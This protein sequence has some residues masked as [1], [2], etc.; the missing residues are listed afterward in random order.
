MSEMMRLEYI[1]RIKTIQKMRL[2]LPDQTNHLTMDESF[3]NQ[4]AFFYSSSFENLFLQLLEKQN[5]KNT[6]R[7]CSKEIPNDGN[8]CDQ[9]CF[10][11]F[12][13]KENKLK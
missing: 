10:W 13:K 5:Q 3:K 6:C 4:L 8:F 9:Y 11:D 2:G 7:N 12:K 1:R